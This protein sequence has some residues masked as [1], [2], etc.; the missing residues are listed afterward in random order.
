MIHLKAAS[1]LLVNAIKDVSEQTLELF[2]VGGG[3][4]WALN[5]TLFKSGMVL[6]Q[7][8]REL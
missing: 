3:C 5:E 6:R 1:S 7:A 4:A 2:R 8:E